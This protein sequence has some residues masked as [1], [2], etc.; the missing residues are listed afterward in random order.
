MGNLL[1][2]QCFGRFLTMQH[3]AVEEGYEAAC[4]AALDHLHVS[5]VNR[6]PFPSW[7][8]AVTHS[9]AGNVKSLSVFGST[10]RAI[11]NAIPISVSGPPTTMPMISSSRAEN[12]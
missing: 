7:R 1:H 6:N 9:C 10:G 2:D 11:Q 3:L 12:A 4:T 5:Q 8:V